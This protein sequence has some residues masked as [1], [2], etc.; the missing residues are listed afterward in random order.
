MKKILIVEDEQ[1]LREGIA[2]A[3][4]D[5]G[6]QVVAACD[7]DEALLFGTAPEARWAAALERIGID[8]RLLS[9]EGGNA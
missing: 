8:P 9:S 7:A 1:N 6:W 4:R 5:R 3:F 2:T